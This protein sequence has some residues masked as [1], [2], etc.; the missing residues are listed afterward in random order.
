MK[1]EHCGWEWQ[2]RVEH[3]RRCPGCYNMQPYWRDKR[4]LPRREKQEEQEQEKSG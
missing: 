2:P 3:P 1:C 4:K